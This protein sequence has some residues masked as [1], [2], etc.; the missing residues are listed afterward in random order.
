MKFIVS[1]NTDIGAKP[2][3]QDCLSVLSLN[4]CQGPM[5]FAV[6][7]DGMGGLQ[8]GEVAS[9]SVVSAFRTWAMEELPALCSK[10]LTEYEIAQQWS[11]IVTDMNVKIMD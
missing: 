1:A 10:P 2:I 9:A 8:M 7:C 3:N 6:L 11:R 4:T 5:A